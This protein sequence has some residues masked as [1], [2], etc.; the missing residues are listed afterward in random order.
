MIPLYTSYLTTADY[1]V[2]ELMDLSMEVIVMIFGFRIGE[3]LIRYYHKYELQDDRDEMFITCLIFVSAV[4]LLLMAVLELNAKNISALVT[5]KAEYRNGFRLIFLCFLLQN[6]YLVSETLLLTEKK[7]MLYSSLSI[8]TLVLNLGLNI[9]L[10]AFYGFGIYGVLVSMLVSKTVNMF[11]VVTYTV[12][13]KKIIFSYAKLLDILR[14]SYPLVFASMGMFVVNFSDRFFL[15]KYCSLEEIGVYSLGYKF[16]MIISV[17]I[18]GPLYRIW[19]TQRFEISKKINAHSTLGRMYTYIVAILFFSGLGIS[20]LV[21]DVIKIIAPSEF[22]EAAKIAPIVVFSYVVFGMSNFFTFGFMIANKTK[23]ISSIQLMVALGNIVL[24]YFL[25][26]EHGI[27]GAAYS[28]LLTFI[29][30]FC[31]M[32]YFSQKLYRVTLEIRRI[33]K[34]FLAAVFIFSACN[35]FSL[36]IIPSMFLKFSVAICYPIVL[37]GVGFFGKEELDTARNIFKDARK[38]FIRS[39]PRKS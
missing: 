2:L 6:V 7:S 16:G 38:R 5:G 33:L 10:I 37:Y 36:P 26:K 13:G 35:L 1:G 34:I 32:C 29:V 23:N 19:N 30:Q 11:I 8:L 14:F 31:V 15:R 4:S 27:Y 21:G 25:V 17:I 9:I 39:N 18:A 24:N 3:G 12:K 20:V 22:H 28:T